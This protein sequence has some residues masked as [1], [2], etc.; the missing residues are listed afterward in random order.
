MAVIKST[1][2]DF[3]QIKASLKT[4]F[5]AQTEF[6]DYDFEASGLSNFLDVL[7]YN[8]HM[9]GLIANMAVNESFLKSAQLRASVTSHAESLG[10]Y[11]RSKTAATANVRLTVSTNITNIGLITIPQYTTFTG[12]VDDISYTFQTLEA[13]TAQNNGTGIFTAVTDA[14][15]T[16]IPIRQGTRKTKTFIVG[17]AADNNVYVIPDPNMDTST[18]TVKVYDTTTSASFNTYVNV[19]NVVRIDNDTK[20]YIVRESPNGFYE[21][22]FSDGNVLGTSPAAGNKIVV[23]YI[24]TNGIDANAASVF[25]ANGDITI[26]NTGYPI[27]VSTVTNSAGGDSKETIESIKINTPLAFA[28]QQRLVT[29]EDYRSIVQQRYSSVVDEVAAWGGNDNIPPEYG[30]VFLSLK[31][32]D[33]TDDNIKQ[34]TKNSIV[35]NI[36]SNL[37]VMSIDTKFIDPEFVYLALTAE[38]NFRQDLSANTLQFTQNQVKQEIVNYV[39]TNLNS[40]DAV[41]RKSSLQTVIDEVAPAILNSQI[42][43]NVQRRFTPIVNSVKDYTVAFPVAL[44]EPDDIFHRI[45]STQFTFNNQTCVIKNQLNSNK[46]QILDLDSIVILDNIGSYNTTTGVVSISGF[47]PTAFIGDSIKISA[48]PA[49]ESVIRPLRGY[50]ISIDPEQTIASGILDNP[51]TASVL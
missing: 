11:P 12:S 19:D 32:K 27:T 28:A 34:V 44:A 38:F 21:M 1:D 13:Y 8:T 45:T 6:A 49:N 22:I 46:L 9:N 10:Y 47:N 24:S 41:F 39:N 16:S 48:V 23:E 31:F 3:D 26:N 25:T 18:I 7:A 4:Y 37:A 43:V 14:G 15:S 2:L 5:E 29:A 30:K 17:D 40:F 20:V 33:G 51:E 50:I 35:S 36:T 42:G